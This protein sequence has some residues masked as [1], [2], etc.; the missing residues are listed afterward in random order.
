LLTALGG[1]AGAL[2]PGWSLLCVGRDDGIGTAL[3]QQACALG[4]E[5]NV[6]FLGMR[7]DIPALLGAADIGI[8]ASHE[9]GFANAI[10]EGMAA[11]LPMVVT[12]VGGNAEAV[13]DGVTGFVVPARDESALGSAI[14]KLAFDR[15]LRRTMGD[16]GRER[17][18]KYFGI[19]R[20]VANYARLYAGLL[21]GKAP[22]D[23]AGLDSALPG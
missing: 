5:D 16:A 8:L 6:K 12:D 18:E 17:V 1:I 22:A 10:L 20:C 11:C 19:D 14:L 23:I 15:H 21:Q 3:M 2:P 9:E 7:T 13:V 4:I